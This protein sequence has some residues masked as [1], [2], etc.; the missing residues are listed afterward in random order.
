MAK[1]CRLCCYL[2]G[3]ALIVIASAAAA[4]RAQQQQT[5]APHE[6]RNAVAPAPIIW[7]TPVMPDGPIEFESA[8]QRHVRLVVV[9]K[10]LEQPWSM[11]F[12]P[13]GSILVTERP[14]RLRI[15]RNSVLDPNPIAGVP[16]VQAQGL[17]GLMDLALHPRFSA[18]KLIYYAYHKPAVNHT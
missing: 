16:R 6:L 3:C 5:L 12:L 17:G 13:D 9:T 2:G 15:V 14:G 8:E 11:A 7:P 10:G 18:N 4:D 1:N